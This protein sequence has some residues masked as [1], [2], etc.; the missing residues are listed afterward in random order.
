MKNEKSQEGFIDLSEFQTVGMPA[1]RAQT[2]VIKGM[3]IVHRGTEQV[4]R[5]ERDPDEPDVIVHREGDTLI[6]I[7]FVCACGRSTSV[8][9]MYD[10]E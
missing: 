4:H 6:S 7:D 2:N 5:S 1:G 3:H 8:Q 9:F 10:Q